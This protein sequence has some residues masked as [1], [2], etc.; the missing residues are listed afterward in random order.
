MA[1]DNGRYPPA[2]IAS[3]TMT[4]MQNRM[5]TTPRVE[6][7]LQRLGFSIRFSPGG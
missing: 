3:D 1:A 5:E 7:R 2:R 4:V 6:N